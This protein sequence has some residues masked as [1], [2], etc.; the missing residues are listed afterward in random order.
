MLPF[1]MLR[2][3]LGKE[4]NLAA[5][6]EWRL[7]NDGDGV[8]CARVRVARVVTVVFDRIERAE[9]YELRSKLHEMQQC[10]RGAAGQR[11]PAW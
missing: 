2:G 5:S 1:R 7:P 4:C 9:R 8:V 11:W 6:S 3:A 10:A